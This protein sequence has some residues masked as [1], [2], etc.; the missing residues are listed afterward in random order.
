MDCLIDVLWR[1]C[2]FNIMRTNLNVILLILWISFSII[3]F[4]ANESKGETWYDSD[5]RPLMVNGEEVTLKNMVIKES[6]EMKNVIE[7]HTLNISRSIIQEV[8]ELRPELITTRSG[9][10]IHYQRYSYGCHF[11]NGYN[12]QLR[13]RRYYSTRSSSRGGIYLNYKIG[14][15]FIHSRY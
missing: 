9:K 10:G 1:L 14:T 3:V 7:E 8:L 13:Y 11:S 12:R 5:G 15:L 4:T 6:E 2:Y